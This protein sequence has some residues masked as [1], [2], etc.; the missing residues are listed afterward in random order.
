MNPASAT[1]LI[2]FWVAAGP[3]APSPAGGSKVL[4]RFQPRV[5]AGS[6]ANT[7]SGSRRRNAIRA[8]SVFDRRFNSSILSLFAVRTTPISKRHRSRSHL[9]FGLL[10]ASYSPL[11]AT[12][13][14]SDRDFLS[15]AAAINANHALIRTHRSPSSLACIRRTLVEPSEQAGTGFSESI[16]V[17][18]SAARFG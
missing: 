16:H 17:P 14:K 5:D 6:C 8:T 2:R 9:V 12:Q 4:P 11:A 1:A 18:V 10:C 13:V 7:A 3:H 15:D